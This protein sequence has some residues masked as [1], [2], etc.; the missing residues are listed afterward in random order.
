MS[1][2]GHP[3][4]YNHIDSSWSYQ[5]MR[6]RGW[7]PMAFTSDDWQGEAVSRGVCLRCSI[8]PIAA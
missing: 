7:G 6:M 5:R 4:M 2:N 3:I 1:G 8:V